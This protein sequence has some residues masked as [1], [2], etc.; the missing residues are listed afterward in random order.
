VLIATMLIAGC[1]REDYSSPKAA[2]RT[3][4]IAVVKGNMD[5]ARRSLCDAKQQPLL[6]QM[7]ALIADIFAA[8]DAA[9]EK[10]GDSGKNVTGGLPSLDDISQAA[11]KTEG[12]LV[13]LAPSDASKLRIVLRKVGTEWKVDL[14]ASLSLDPNDTDKATQFIQSA[15]KLVKEHIVSIRNGKYR[16]AQE[17][18]AALQGCVRN[19]MAM[20]QVM[21]KL[22]NALMG[23]LRSKDK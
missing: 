14:L 13:M 4:Y 1:N 17:A 8:Q 19:P 20:A 9:V 22:G 16:S 21:G 6:D 18:E 7:Q 10:F 3:F 2:A 23:S 12:D 11:E 15:R 5:R